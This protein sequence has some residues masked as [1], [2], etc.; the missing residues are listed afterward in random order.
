MR[1]VVRRTPAGPSPL[2]SRKVCSPTL[3]TS[4]F[5]HGTLRAEQEVYDA[6]ATHDVD[7]LVRVLG[8]VVCA[9]AVELDEHMVDW[10]LQCLLDVC[11]DR[12]HCGRKCMQRQGFI[13]WVAVDWV[14]VR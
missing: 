6:G 10:V 13:G 7:R 2:P 1:S 8:D 11:T 3:A 5:V 9:C 4:F 12:G 14:A